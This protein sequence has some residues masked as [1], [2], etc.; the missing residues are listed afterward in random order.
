MLEFSVEVIGP[1]FC[2]EINAATFSTFNIYY[3]T[4]FRLPMIWMHFIVV[5]PRQGACNCFTL[6]SGQ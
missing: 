4:K 1:V 6:F 5:L 2:Q 3:L